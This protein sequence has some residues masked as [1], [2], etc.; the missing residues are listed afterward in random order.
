MTEIVSLEKASPFEKLSLIEVGPEGAGKSWLAAT[1][2]KPVLFLDFDRRSNA[3]AHKHGVYAITKEVVDP[4]WPNQPTAYQNTINVLGE[5]EQGKIICG[6]AVPRTLVFDSVHTFARAC[7]AYAL[8]TTPDI[9][10]VINAA[11]QQIHLPKGFDAWNAEMSL[12]EG[13]IT[14]AL[15]IP[16]LDVIATLHETA[17][18]APESTTERPSFTGKIT[19]YPVR[20]KLLLKYF[21]EVWRLERTSKIPV[22]QVIPDWKFTCKSNLGIDKMEEPDIAKAIAKAGY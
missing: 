21:N 8:F 11:G 1:G 22:V 20:Y 13:A 19:V 5:L 10:R 14:R 15:A 16:G 7:M 6:G 2:R 12:I 17:E 3:V 9:R 18:E 4:A